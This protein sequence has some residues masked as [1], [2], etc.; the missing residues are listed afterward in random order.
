MFPWTYKLKYLSKSTLQVFL[1]FHVSMFICLAERVTIC[2]LFLFEIKNQYSH[3][4]YNNIQYK[5]SESYPFLRVRTASLPSPSSCI[6]TLWYCMHESVHSFSGL[7]DSATS[8]GRG[9]LHIP[10]VA[11][12]NV[13]ITLP[14]LRTFCNGGMHTSPDII[15]CK[16]R[17]KNYIYMN[18]ILCYRSCYS[19]RQKY[20][21]TTMRVLKF[22]K[23][24]HHQILSQL[25]V[26]KTNSS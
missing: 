20:S 11:T 5:M 16:K 3:I 22:T 9:N 1:C 25:Y 23:K 17:G 7:L 8:L 4:D 24:S 13:V 2:K 21:E 15:A 10:P 26:L 19:I 6:A 12:E 14:F 18:T